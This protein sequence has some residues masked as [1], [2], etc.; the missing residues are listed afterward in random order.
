VGEKTRNLLELIPEQR[1]ESEDCADGTV[2]V[3]MPRYGEGWFSRML[4][5]IFRGAPVRVQLDDVGTSVWRLCDGR[6]NVREIGSEIHGQFGDSIEPV[7][8]RLGE[9]FKRM[10]RAGIIGWKN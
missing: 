7:Y 6:R 8:D 3:I 9:F 4:E 10:D 1:R 5:R 2:E